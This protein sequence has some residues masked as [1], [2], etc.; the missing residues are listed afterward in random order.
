M[1]YLYQFFYS[2]SW[3]IGWVMLSMAVAV[4]FKL[5]KAAQFDKATPVA[6]TKLSRWVWLML[7]LIKSIKADDGYGWN[8]LGCIRLL[9][10]L[11]EGGWGWVSVSYCL[12]YVTE[13]QYNYFFPDIW[14]EVD[15]TLSATEE[16]KIAE[17]YFFKNLNENVFWVSLSFLF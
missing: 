11:A 2:R 12:A 8:L 1:V 17:N 5:H 4:V 16:E 13:L 9:K 7:Q 3:S 15:R 6:L 14:R 10:A